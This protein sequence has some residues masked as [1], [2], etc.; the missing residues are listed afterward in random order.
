MVHQLPY[1]IKFEEQENEVAR[2]MSVDSFV[3]SEIRYRQD[4]DVPLYPMMLTLKL[5]KPRSLL[6]MIKSRPLSKE[7]FTLDLFG[8]W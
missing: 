5:L 3:P 6:P 7:K 2:K 8:S 1:V 4:A